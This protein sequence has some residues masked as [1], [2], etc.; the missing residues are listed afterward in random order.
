MYHWQCM[1]QGKAALVSLSM[2][3][4]RAARFMVERVA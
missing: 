1:G 2:R 3:D 4:P